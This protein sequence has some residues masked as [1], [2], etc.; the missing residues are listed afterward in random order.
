M[1]QPYAVTIIGYDL[2]KMNSVKTLL[3]KP[4]CEVLIDS[5]Y[6]N[7]IPEL[8]SSKY[9]LL[10]TDSTVDFTSYEQLLQRIKKQNCLNQLILLYRSCQTREISAAYRM[11]VK[12]FIEITN[13]NE[14][15]L[16]LT[17][18]TDANEATDMISPDFYRLIADSGKKGNFHFDLNDKEQSIIHLI[19][20]G[21]S[22]HE[23]ADEL[24]LSPRTI[25][26]HRSQILKKT[27]ASNTVIMLKKALINGYIS[28]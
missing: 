4:S 15:K 13:I 1:T 24:C 9:Y 19:W 8:P 2:L 26:R 28:L 11:G 27:R 21:Y 18:A 22:N 23:I 3:E 17:E 5:S 25:E 12:K 16:K 20:E 7:L 10:L 6:G 14:L